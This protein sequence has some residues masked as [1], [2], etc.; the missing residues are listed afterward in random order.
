GSENFQ[1]L[2]DAGLP[3]K[4]AEKLDE[5]YVAGLVAHSDLDERAIEAL[6]EFNEDG[7]LAVLQQFKDSDLS[8][9]QNKSAFLCG[10]M[11]TYRQRE[12]QGTKVA[13]SSKGPDEAKIKALL[14]RTG[15]T[16]DV[17]TG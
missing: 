4:V 3:Q 9:V 2:L 16:L 5:I 17:T 15:Y 1:T 10:V 13:D 14:E 12:K 8:H 6:K 11:K 7:A